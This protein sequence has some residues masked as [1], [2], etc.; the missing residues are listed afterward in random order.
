L[1]T[2]RTLLLVKEKIVRNPN[3]SPKILRIVL[4]KYLSGDKNYSLAASA[5]ENVNCPPEILAKVLERRNDDS[6]SNSA[7]RNPNCP[8]EALVKYLD[9]E[10]NCVFYSIVENPNCPQKVLEKLFC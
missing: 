9:G 7:A 8:E 2:S 4:E 10:P 5:A 1:D 3:C 6:V